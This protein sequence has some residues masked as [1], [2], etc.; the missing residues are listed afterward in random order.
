MQGFQGFSFQRVRYLKSNVEQVKPLR[1]NGSTCF[2]LYV[3]Y[4]YILI[5]KNE[6]ENIKIGLKKITNTEQ[7]GIEAGFLAENVAT[8]NEEAR[9]LQGIA[10][11]QARAV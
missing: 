11:F 7:A 9:C 5:L 8:Y 2:V 6:I 4:F 10:G 3:R 1:R